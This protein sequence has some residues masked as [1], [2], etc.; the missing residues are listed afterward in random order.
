MKPWSIIVTAIAATVA[1]LQA[2]AAA[3]DPG[4]FPLASVQAQGIQITQEYGPEQAD[5]DLPSGGAHIQLIRNGAP[6]PVLHI[7]SGGLQSRPSEHSNLRVRLG[8]LARS[9]WVVLQAVPLQ[10]R[11]VYDNGAESPY[12]SPDAP[13]PWNTRQLN[14][15][16]D[17]LYRDSVVFADLGGSTLPPDAMDLAFACPNAPAGRISRLPAH[18]RV[19]LA[20]SVSVTTVTVT[21]ALGVMT[22]VPGLG[23]NAP[24]VMLAPG[25]RVTWSIPPDALLHVHSVT[26]L[27]AN[28]VR[29]HTAG[30]TSYLNS[31]NQTIMQTLSVLVQPPATI[32]IEV[33]DHLR[34]ATA[35]ITM[36]E[37]PLIGKPSERNR[38]QTPDRIQEVPTDQDAADKP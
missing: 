27:T 18:L 1:P 35:D 5:A 8:L 31:A 32:A 34:T 14:V 9:G 10:A 21:P 4:P 22:P 30:G 38:T 23:A 26:Y 28:G 2:P 11:V 16:S 24:Q 15:L 20:E 36:H 13:S 37:L 17:P 25:G 7:S 3:Q 12:Q 33:Y 6:E 19:I 29:L